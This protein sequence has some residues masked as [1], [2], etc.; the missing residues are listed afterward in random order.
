VGQCEAP[1]FGRGDE[2]P[3]EVQLI[4]C[5]TDYVEYYEM[6]SRR[7]NAFQCIKRL[8]VEE[9]NTGDHETE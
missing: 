3:V 9:Y 8:I 5:G 2:G 7:E 6:R 4:E 1:A